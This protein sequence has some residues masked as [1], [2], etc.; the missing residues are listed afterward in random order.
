M[1]IPSSVTESPKMVA[2]GLATRFVVH[3]RIT[4]AVVSLLAFP[5]SLQRRF[6][7]CCFLL[8]TAITRWL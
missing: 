6:L 3:A 2:I 5:W 1:P 7:G 8:H 4:K